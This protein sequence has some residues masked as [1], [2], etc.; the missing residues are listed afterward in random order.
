[1]TTPTQKQTAET[2]QTERLSEEVLASAKA[3]QRTAGEAVHKFITTV[4]EAIRERRDAIREDSAL[5]ALR[6]TL[7]DAGLEM[8]DK[9]ITAQ[10]EFLR[11]VVRDAGNV[12]NK[13]EG[14]KR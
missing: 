2:E 12:L 11:S 6:K 1:M 9:L 3:G 14:D 7:I 5:H 4:D 8:S 10:Y 13:A